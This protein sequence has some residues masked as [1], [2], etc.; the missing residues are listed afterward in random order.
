MSGAKVGSRWAR[1]YP[2]DI[3]AIAR[4]SIGR[5]TVPTE[6]YIPSRV[7][8]LAAKETRS[9]S[10][11]ARWER[12]Q[13]SFPCSSLM[14]FTSLYKNSRFSEPVLS[15]ERFPAIPAHFTKKLTGS[16][17]SALGHGYYRGYRSSSTPEPQ[18]RD[19]PGSRRHFLNHCVRVLRSGGPLFGQ[20]LLQAVRWPT[21]PRRGSI[22]LR[23]SP[24]HSKSARML[25]VRPQVSQIPMI[26]LA[27][28]LQTLCLLLSPVFELTLCSL[29]I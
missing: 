15:V 27:F 21:S 24:A 13:C 16:P 8:S 7:A 28:S 3:P 18:T 17:Y 11:E 26:Y 20:R 10:L 12:T 19:Y 25:R 4:L 22:G 29:A 14:P 23:K 9:G 5:I 6:T 2:R 1:H